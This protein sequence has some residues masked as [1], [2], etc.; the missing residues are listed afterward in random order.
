MQEKSG[1]I[2]IENLETVSRKEIADFIRSTGC[3]DKEMLMEN[4]ELIVDDI[5][6]VMADTLRNG[7]SIMLKNIGSLAVTHKAER[8][9]V[10]NPKTGEETTVSSRNVVTLKKTYKTDNKIG[11][12]EICELV[13]EK[14]PEMRYK[15]VHAIFTQF[16]R[17]IANVEKGETRVEIRGLGVFAP[18]LIKPRNS[19]NPKTG[20]R[21]ISKE[22]IK[23]MFKCSTVIFD[24]LNPELAEA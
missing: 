1:K 24:A 5:V 6:D 22:K 11:M 13:Q 3:V 15:D 7:T 8:K 16:L 2:H 10:R 4:M 19:R 14:N 18:S 20:E 23:T 17:P 21:L 9:G 12:A